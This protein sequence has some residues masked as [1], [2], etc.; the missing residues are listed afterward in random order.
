MKWKGTG[1]ELEKDLLGAPESLLQ[2]SPGWGS[3]RV[4][5]P[6]RDSQSEAAPPCQR[7]QGSEPVSPRGLGLPEK[8]KGAWVPAYPEPD[9]ARYLGL[10]GA[11]GRAQ[12]GVRQERGLGRKDK[13]GAHTLGISVAS[14]KSQPCQGAQGTRGE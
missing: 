5:R 4:G 9:T 8:P 3:G 11:K 12:T 2:A 10:G 13:G 6:E 1:R 14:P 7:P